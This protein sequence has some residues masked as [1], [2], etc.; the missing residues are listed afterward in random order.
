[1]ST[2]PR[3]AAP[4]LRRAAALALLTALVGGVLAVGVTGPGAAAPSTPPAA[5]AP[6]PTAPARPDVLVVEADDMRADDLQWMPRTRALLERRGLV[7]TNSFA[8]NPLCCPSRS[9]FLTGRYSHNTGVLTH[10]LPYGWASF[11]D[12]VT[13]ATALRSTGYRTSMIGKYLNGYGVQELRPHHRGSGLSGRYV[14]PGWTRWMGAID[15][16]NARLSKRLGVTGGTYNYARLAQNVDGVPR[17]TRGY[18]TTVT[19]EQVRRTLDGFSRGRA[20]WFVWWTPVAPHFG[21]PPEPDDPDLVVESSG[22]RGRLV[23]PARP[24]WVRGSLDARLTRAP[25]IRADGTTE[26][27]VADKPAWMQRPELGAEERAGVLESAR[28]RAEALLVLDQEVATTLAR[29][30]RTPRGRAAYVVLTSDNGYYLGEHRQP[31]GKGTLLEPSLRVPLLVAGPGV[32]VGVRHDP[33]TTIDLAPTILGW[34]G[35]RLPGL[36]GVDLA[37]T[38]TDGDQGWTRPVLTEGRMRFALPS[39]GTDPGLTMH[40]LRLGGWSLTRYATGEVELYDM[41]DDPLQLRNVA[42]DPAYAAERR[43]LLGVLAD[44]QDCRGTACTRPLPDD[45]ALG[46]ARTRAVTLAQQR[47]TEEYYGG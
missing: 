1:M 45:L 32:P 13:L 42:D 17:T 22:S 41:A 38:I 24:A 8:P 26:A 29:L 12:R 39:D 40:G 37:P 33:V 23:T 35:G 47:A 20:P 36:D 10:E 7:F 5:A 21:G 18:S 4:T 30:W 28:Q 46:P 34:T 14:P 9:S 19:G 16:G 44:L 6:A 15:F 25:G 27:V 2:T 31:Q 43:R 11:D 3:L